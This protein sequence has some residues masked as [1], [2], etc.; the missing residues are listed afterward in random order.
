MKHVKVT[1]HKGFLLSSGAFV[2]LNILSNI[3]EVGF[4]AVLVRLPE[5]D[6]S[7]AQTLFR[8]FFI[9]TAPLASIQLMVGKEISALRALDRHGEAKHFASLSIRYVLLD[10]KSVV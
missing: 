6:Y 9:I 10:R 5:G 2:A 7:T 4:N 8:I 1:S 3:F